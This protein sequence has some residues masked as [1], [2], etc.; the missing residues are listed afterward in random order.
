MNNIKS[1]NISGINLSIYENHMEIKNC[2]L[3]LIHSLTIDKSRSLNWFTRLNS[4]KNL[5]VRNLEN[6]DDIEAV[7]DPD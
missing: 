1:L 2:N 6:I 5:I 3:P 4:L 7:I